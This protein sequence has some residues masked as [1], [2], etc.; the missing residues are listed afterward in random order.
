M[1]KCIVASAINVMC[2]YDTEISYN[3]LREAV[4]LYYGA[5]IINYVGRVITKGKD[6][7]IF[8]IIRTKLSLVLVH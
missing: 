5:S 4:Y 3:L 2:S 8:C 7:R 6:T 1:A